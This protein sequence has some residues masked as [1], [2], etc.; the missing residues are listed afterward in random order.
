MN[1]VFRRLGVP[2]SSERPL[3][4]HE[5]PTTGLT[6]STAADPTQ[7]VDLAGRSRR[8]QRIA[9]VI[10]L[11][12]WSSHWVVMSLARSFRYPEQG[13]GHVPRR[14]VVTLLAIGLSMV[15][16]RWLRQS[17]GQSLGR[18]AALAVLLAF[19]GCMIHT[20]LNMYLFL[21]YF[22]PPSFTVQ[23]WLLAYTVS[24]VDF[25][26]AYT[27][28]SLMLLAL[29][30]GDELIASQNRISTLES[31]TNLARLNTLR[32]QLNPHFLFNSLNAVAGL[33]SNERNREAEAMVVSLSDLLRATLELDSPQEI[34]LADELELQELYLEIEKIRFPDRMRTHLSISEEVRDAMVPPLITQPLVENAIKHGVS[35]SSRPVNIAIT[36]SAIGTELV[37]EV[38]QSGG[39]A[40]GELPSGTGVGL[41]NVAERLRLHFGDA[42]RLETLEAPGGFVARLR[43]PLHAAQ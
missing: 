29:T 16:V 24:Q 3:E 17:Q 34:R 13:W 12:F 19:A 37:V 20:A 26:W 32:Y 42:G 27:A 33:I 21:P 9:L 25:I 28:L 6:L 2:K 41:R 30:Y 36:A 4:I 39:N 8:L 7:P 11:V 22:K 14:A 38:A 31:Q 1:D 35:R 40:I 5:R 15:I 10:I 23:G 18:R 43:L